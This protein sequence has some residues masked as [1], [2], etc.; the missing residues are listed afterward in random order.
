MASNQQVTQGY[1]C[2]ILRVTFFYVINGVKSTYMYIGYTGYTGYTR[3]LVLVHKIFFLRV[4][5]FPLT[6]KNSHGKFFPLI[7]FKKRK[8]V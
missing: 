8:S 6:E 4:N 2:E 5:L 1:T 3:F 7:H